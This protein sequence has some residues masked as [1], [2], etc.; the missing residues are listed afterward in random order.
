M[1]KFTLKYGKEEISFSVPAKQLLHEIIGKEYPPI[2]DIPQAVREALA[3]PID[4]PP[5]G[6]LVRPGEKVAI[7]VSDITRAWQ[8]MPLVLPEIIATLNKAGVPDSNITIIIAVGGHRQ[9]T[10]QE[11]VQLCGK[12]IYER[13][14]IVNH[15]A[16]DADNMVYF[17]KT[18]LGTEVSINKI[19]AEADRLILTGGIVYH[20][21]AGF[22]GGRKSIVPGISSIKTIRQNHLWGLGREVGAGSNPHAASRKTQGNELHEDMM[23]VGGFINPDFIVNMV[24]TPDG[25]FGGVFA[26]NWVSAWKEGCKLVD[27]LYGVQID[28]LADIV[29]T[30]AGGF[31][32]DIN[33][34]QTGKTMD[35]A[36]YAVKKGGAVVL[37][38]ECADIYEPEEFS[39]WFQYNDKLSMEKALRADFGIPGWVALK[40]VECSS[41]ATYVMVTRPEN[42][43][44]VSKTGMIA[45]TTIED[46]LR[47]AREKCGTDNPTYTVM[48]Q[49]ANTLPILR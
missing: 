19:A 46:A 39:R 13:I 44:F 20:Y 40:E 43:E 2:N 7:A 35:N 29:V 8:Q 45:A 5:L 42:A 25:Q 31:P 9:N 15:D 47:I 17:G 1:K 30:T 28:N 12:E 23:E 41:H 48:P 26:G 37:L 22:G 24:P 32:K 21:M 3:K 27:Q 16:F 34:Y 38:S 33:L 49:G 14:K 4:A 11:F 36:Y 10:E 18:S 6:E